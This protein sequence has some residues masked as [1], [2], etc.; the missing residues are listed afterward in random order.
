MPSLEPPK[1]P[2]KN[3]RKG[4]FPGTFKN[5]SSLLYSM[6]K[7]SM[8]KRRELKKGLQVKIKRTD[9]NLLE[10]I[11][12]QAEA[13][14]VTMRGEYPRMDLATLSYWAGFSLGKL[15][16][17]IPTHETCQMLDQKVHPVRSLLYTHAGT[18]YQGIQG[19]SPEEKSIFTSTAYYFKTIFI[20]QCAI[21]L[22]EE[23][24]K[25]DDSYLK[26]LKHAFTQLKP[27]YHRT[28]SQQTTA[29]EEMSHRLEKPKPGQIH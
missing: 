10:N 12:S 26:Q 5:I 2:F 9:A 7:G 20:V 13:K 11:I 29:F 3:L 28:Y 27:R 18:L 14:A 24:K 22:E 1:T 16:P 21:I 15:Y 23:R 8:V 25:P 17:F 6:V 4:K 19:V